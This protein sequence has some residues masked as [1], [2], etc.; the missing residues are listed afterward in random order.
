MW[1]ETR[2]VLS[3]DE[4]IDLT[5]ERAQRM[6]I[7]SSFDQIVRRAGELKAG[8]FD[9][10]GTLTPKN[11]WQSLD[12]FLTPELQAE[13]ARD[14]DWYLAH[15]HNGSGHQRTLEDPDWFHGD[16]LEGN[17]PVAEGAWIAA[18]IGRFARCNVTKTQVVDAGRSLPPRDG[19]LDLLRLLPTRVIISFGLEQLIQA[20]AHHHGVP[21]PVAASRLLFSSNETVSGSHM[22][23]VGSATKEHA[24][25]RFRELSGV[26][27]SHLMVVG[28]SPV[29]VHMMH[30][31]GFNVL[32]IP[33]TEA[34]KKLTD[35]RDNH[36]SAMWDRLTLILICD[37]LRPLVQLIETA[38]SGRRF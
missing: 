32:I 20:W 25:N 33:P 38:R 6:L 34:D 10:D 19:A 9:F 29:D 22:N 35:F 7:R 4:T 5:R 11:Q 13:N 12:R 31:Q 24:C 30:P 3:F 27:E 26:E 23:L 1:L 2:H 15:T 28:D 17:K 16:L 37:S 21:C 14:L 8:A 18:S 36:L